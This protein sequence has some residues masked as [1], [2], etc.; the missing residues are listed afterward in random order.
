VHRTQIYL[1]DSQY[2]MR[3]ARAR[4]EGRS[5]AAV[6]RGILEEHL[7]GTGTRKRDRFGEV[8]GIGAGDGA[9]VAEHVDD[10]L[11]AAKP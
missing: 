5:L 3:R 10:F 11:Y 4:R 9:A 1:E 2:E 8:I 6:I 7:S